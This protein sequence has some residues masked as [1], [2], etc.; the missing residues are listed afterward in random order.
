MWVKKKCWECL[1][2]SLIEV[3]EGIFSQVLQRSK[4][5]HSNSFLFS[6]IDKKEKQILKVHAR[7]VHP[8]LTGQ[9]AL[10]SFRA[11]FQVSKVVISFKNSP[12]S[13]L[14]VKIT[15]GPIFTYSVYDKT[16]SSV[17]I[18]NNLCVPVT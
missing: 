9:L 2:K 8:I 16:F 12:H 6:K 1:C 18:L 7:K 14:R 17:V 3:L 5:T 10:C 13:S 15:S 11:Y 4:H